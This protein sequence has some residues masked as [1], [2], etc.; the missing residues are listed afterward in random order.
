MSA[1]TDND[2]MPRH[3]PWDWLVLVVVAWIAAYSSLSPC[4]DSAIAALGLLRQTHSGDAV[5]LF[6]CDAPKVESWF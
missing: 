4:A 2:N 1:L 6:S 3:S 5:H